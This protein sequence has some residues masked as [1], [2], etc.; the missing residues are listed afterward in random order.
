MINI[1][2]SSTKVN[3][4]K[5]TFTLA[6]KQAHCTLSL[7]RIFLVTPIEPTPIIITVTIAANF[8]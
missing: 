4:V 7:L 5:G 2:K 1:T 6:P 8:I 3:L